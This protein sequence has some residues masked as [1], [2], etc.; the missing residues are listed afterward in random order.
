LTVWNKLGCQDMHLLLD[1]SEL[2][3]PE[4]S[5]GKDVCEFRDFSIDENDPIKERVRQTYQEMHTH[6]T[7]DYVNKQIENWTKFD[8]HQMT[9][10]AAL[11]LLN[12]LVD[13][14]DPDVDVPNIVHAFQTAESI[15]KMYPDDD[16]FHL[17]GLIH[18]LGKVMAIWGMP[19]WAV[20][21][22][23]FPVGCAPAKT[24]VYQDMTFDDNVDMKNP[25]YNTRL[26]QY[27]E[28]CGIENLTLSW[29]HDEY[30]YRV[31]V[32][33]GATLP[34]QALHMIRYHSFYPWHFAGDY[35]QFMVEEDIQTKKWVQIFN[36]FDLYT[37]SDEMPDVEA[38]KSY[39]QS[40]IDKYVPGLVKW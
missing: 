24:V 5:A 12:T 10:M 1:P 18:D 30:L 16:W 20:V 32:N 8:K 4:L 36:K 21:G 19:Q 29:G 17:T 39:Y 13:E 27:E 9:V 3:R 28:G 11:E 31:L 7:V 35:E 34:P 38:L 37:K 22:D 25:K 26:G 40:L 15:R 14:S 23:T 6:Q 2:Y 33:H